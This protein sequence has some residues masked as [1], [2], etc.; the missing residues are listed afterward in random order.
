MKPPKPEIIMRQKGIG[1]ILKENAL[2]V[3]PHQ[4]EYSWTQKQVR[5]LFEDLAKA[6]SDQP[7]YFLGTIAAIRE[8]SGALRVI[9]GQQRLATLTILICA[10][11]NYLRTL[12][13]GEKWLADSLKEFLE[14]ADRSQRT[15]IPKMRLNSNDNDFFSKMLL[16]ESKENWPDPILYSHRLI[17]SSFEEAYE[18]VANIVSGFNVRDHGDALNKWIS[19]IQDAAEVILLQMPTG[20]NAYK[21]FETLNDRGL[22][23]TQADMV[24]SY[25]FEQAETNDRLP[26]AEASWAKLRGALDSL[27]GDK[28]ISV[29]FIRHAMILIHGPLTKDEILDVVQSMAKGAGSAVSLSKKLEKLAATYTATFFSDHEKWSPYPDAIKLAIQTLNFFGIQP[30]RPIMMAIAESFS[31]N[32][33]LKAYEMMIS[34]GVRIMIASSTSSGSVEDI[35]HPAA[36]KIFQGKIS[37]A[38]ELR[39]AVEP[40]FPND[41]RFRSAFATTTVSKTYL[42]KYY[43]RTL[44]RVVKKEPTPWYNINNDK[45]VI[46]LE[47]ILPEEPGENWPQ[48]TA[49]EAEANWRRLG[50]MALH[51]KKINSALQNAPFSEKRPTYRECPYNLTSQI[52]GVDEWNVKVIGERQEQMAEFALKAWPY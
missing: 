8:E 28:D 21:M 12:G 9:D 43:L 47:H 39:A 27:Q 49:G 52:A 31:P 15:N 3:P 2:K 11:R 30:F 29:V 10:I 14:Y 26:E 22:D 42:A 36:N 46:N 37:T 7:E 45:E 35:L 6:I 41:Q 16:A 25:L 34:L 51:S 17:R 24:K 13:D 32:E 48:F 38:K 4:R 50:N 33:A 40:I 18:R 23:T 19:Y 44:E 5:K 20:Y 1:S